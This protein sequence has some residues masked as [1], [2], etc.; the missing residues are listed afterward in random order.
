[1]IFSVLLKPPTNMFLCEETFRWNEEHEELSKV[2]L[3]LRKLQEAYWDESY[4]TLILT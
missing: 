4:P 2:Y 1:M 3:D